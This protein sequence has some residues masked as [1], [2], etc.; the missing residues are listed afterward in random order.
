[1]VFAG[2]FISSA[3]FI[4]TDVAG[5]TNTSWDF[6]NVR[7]DGSTF[8]DLTPSF[9][10]DNFTFN[11]AGTSVYFGEYTSGDAERIHQC[12]LSTAWDMTTITEPPATTHT[13]N[14]S[15]I[16]TPNA[17]MC[18]NHD[19]TKLYVA[20]RLNSDND[21]LLIELTLSSA[22]D[23]SSVSSETTLNIENELGSSTFKGPVYT[24]D[25]STGSEYLFVNTNNAG[26][27][28]DVFQYEIESTFS[29][30]NYVG[31]KDLTSIASSIYSS[32]FDG[33]DITLA[34]MDRTQGSDIWFKFFKSD[35]VSQ[36]L[37]R[38]NMTTDWDITTA[39][40]TALDI[41]KIGFVAPDISSV[42]FKPDGLRMFWMMNRASTGTSGD[43]DVIGFDVGVPQ[44]N[45]CPLLG[46]LE[47]NATVS[48]LSH[49]NEADFK[50][51]S[52]GLHCVVLERDSSTRVI[53]H[54][55]TLGT[56]YDG[57][58]ADIG[59]SS[60]NLTVGD[61]CY[62]VAIKDS[63]TLF[64][65]TD[66]REIFRVDLAS[67]WVA[68]GATVTSILTIPNTTGSWAAPTHFDVF[69]SGVNFILLMSNIVR[70]WT[71]AS[72]WD[73]STVTDTNYYYQNEDIEGSLNLGTD[74][75]IIG[76][77]SYSFVN[78]GNQCILG[79]RTEL[80]AF[81]FDTSGDPYNFDQIT[82]ANMIDYQRRFF[83]ELS[84]ANYR[85]FQFSK[86]SVTSKSQGMAMY[87]SGIPHA[88]KFL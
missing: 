39:T 40:A 34:D 84:S 19:G 15:Y 43:I 21:A 46:S 30:K 66:G 75:T 37:V 38:V 44:I 52:D 41:T 3:R 57:Q 5:P 14:P 87:S 68:T 51:S 81:T 27:Q 85:T 11:S 4:S 8:H 83:G 35:P 62:N 71:L 48:N 61:D 1:M 45:I 33:G 26:N 22:Y 78:N 49:G 28:L 69:E 86:D 10:Y 67:A 77:S 20:G 16:K 70:S 23:I 60:G 74:S 13:M 58:S 50:Y 53:I 18:F 7:I 63:T 17:G 59:T 72:A 65:I 6:S 12:T 47:S 55:H 56:A 80:G 31:T 42:F 82:T 54:I 88:V 24:R 25:S 79:A 9:D 36:G 73:F 2:F 32:D 64:V 29:T 76:F